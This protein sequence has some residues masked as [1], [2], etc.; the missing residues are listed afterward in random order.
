LA[1]ACVSGFQ[2]DQLLAQETFNHL[3]GLVADYFG[4]GLDIRLA[5]ANGGAKK[6]KS[7]TKSYVNE[8]PEVKQAVAE[9]GAEVLDYRPRLHD[10]DAEEES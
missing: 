10:A 2:R 8:R 6:D 3:L 5:A 1:I 7:E 9:F 4:P